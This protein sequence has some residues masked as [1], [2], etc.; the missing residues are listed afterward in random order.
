VN[1]TKALLSKATGEESEAF[2][3]TF[4]SFVESLDQKIRASDPAYQW[5]IGNM[6]DFGRIVSA[7]FFFF[8]ER[9]RGPQ[10]THNFCLSHSQHTTRLAPHW[11]SL[12]TTA[13]AETSSRVQVAVQELQTLF[14]RH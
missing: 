4:A 13:F 12:L 3:L 5:I 10:Q 14:P 2:R 7:L 8:I 1:K 9:E 11:D 6:R